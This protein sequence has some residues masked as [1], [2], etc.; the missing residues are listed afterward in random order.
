MSNIVYRAGVDNLSLVVGQKQT[1]QGMAGR[2][3]FPPI[4]PF[5]LQF[6]MSLKLANL[7]NF[8]KINA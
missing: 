6:M 1:V 3:N 8:N 2:I 7:W 4:I 5:Y